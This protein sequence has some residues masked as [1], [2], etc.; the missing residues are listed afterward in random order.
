M[1]HKVKFELGQ[2]T[3]PGRALV[4]VGPDRSSAQAGLITR[5]APALTLLIRSLTPPL[6]PSTIPDLNFFRFTL[7][8]TLSPAGPSRPG[9]RAGGHGRGSA[10]YGY[11]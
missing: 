3:D 10:S 4:L 7:Y 11:D 6:L 1:K 9:W 5:S 8:P 2:Q